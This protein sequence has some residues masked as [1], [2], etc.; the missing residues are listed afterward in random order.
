MNDDRTG[1]WLRQAEHIFG[2]LWNRKCCAPQSR[3]MYILGSLMGNQKSYQLLFVKRL[4]ILLCQVLEQFRRFAWYCVVQRNKLT[5]WRYANGN[6]IIK[7]CDVFAILD[8]FA[9]HG[10]VKINCTG[11][12]VYYFIIKKI[13]Q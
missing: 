10:K 5:C 7:K 4:I 9:R 6:D 11:P 12:W 2:H 3:W 13:K 8:I 1:L